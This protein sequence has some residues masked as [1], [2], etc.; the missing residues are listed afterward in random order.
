MS[1]KVPM[2][3]TE[4]SSILQPNKSGSL[5]LESTVRELELSDLTVDI[6]TVGMEL[7]RQF[8]QNPLAP[9]AVLLDRDRLVGVIS[10]QRFWE[11]MSR[12]YGLDLFG[13]RPLLEFH[14]L[15]AV[16]YLL[17]P[18]NT[19]IAVAAQQTLE[20]SPDLINEPLV[21]EVKPG[22][23]HLLD[24]HQLLLAQSTIHQLTTQLLQEQTQARLIQAEKMSALGEMVASVAHEILNPV[25]FICGN[26]N[27][28]DH[29]G[30]DLL[31]VLATYERSFPQSSPAIAEMK[32]AID[33]EFVVTDF[34]QVVASIRVG[35]ERLRKTI[36]ALKSF[37][38]M[39]E[40]TPHPV[41]IHACLDDTLL[42]L[43][44]RLKNTIEVVKNYGENTSVQGFSGQLG[45]VFMNLLSNAIDALTD[46]TRSRNKPEWKPKITITT[47]LKTDP[48]DSILIRIE[49][50]GIGIS[51]DLQAHIF[52]TF[53]TT[54]P[55]GKGTGLGLT[56]TR[57]I[58]EKHQGQLS[59]K[60]ELG[61]GTC[62]EVLL[63]THLHIERE[64]NRVKMI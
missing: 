3:T 24:V 25:N 32:D 53:F 49:D 63:P 12:P 2:L 7:S 1:A 4:I 31:E 62:F 40:V 38:H 47:E 50:N 43:Q 29:Y 20:R 23:Y 17:F 22:I 26:I 19:L 44:G 34:P 41:D 13:R 15:T 36:S 54:K 8:E 57:Q 58:V 60:S 14:E 10:R 37:S 61:N 18:G 35:A 27:Y 42:I 30:N 45:Q 52:E 16:E 51:E 39:D 46:S 6:Y 64:Q 33:L 55:V 9:G 59:F 5:T 48:H 28:L 56:I 21:V 11:R